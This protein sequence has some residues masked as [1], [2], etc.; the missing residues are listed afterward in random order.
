MANFLDHA[1]AALLPAAAA[2]RAVAAALLGGGGGPPGIPQPPAAVQNIQGV[3]E[4]GHP[5]LTS[6]HGSSQCI[7]S[8]PYQRGWQEGV[9]RFWRRSCRATRYPTHHSIPSPRGQTPGSRPV[10]A[11]SCPSQQQADQTKPKP[12]HPP[13]SLQVQAAAARRHRLCSAA[14]CGKAPAPPGLP[15]CATCRSTLPAEPSAPRAA[16]PPP[17]TPRPAHRCG[18]SPAGGERDGG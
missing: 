4:R 8:P 11:P 17:P 15:A 3:M 10:S 2:A 16:P 18:H 1:A 7:A 9:G 5:G 13:P 6:P 14:G 12:P